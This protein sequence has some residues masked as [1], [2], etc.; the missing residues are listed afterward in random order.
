MTVE[1]YL[2]VTTESERRTQLIDGVIVVNEPK[3]KHDLIQARLIVALGNWVDA[4]EGRGLAFT[5]T[6]VTIDE[7]NLFAPD[8]LWIAEHHLPAD[9]DTYPERIPDICVEVRS[10]STWRHDTG[11]K[12]TG[13][14]RAGLPELWLVNDAARR[15]RVFRRSRPGAP[16]FDVALDL[17]PADELTSPQLPGF[18]LA[19]ERLFR[20]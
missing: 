17:G 19:L 14:E 12:K 8:A 16:A 2:A 9:L 13:Y 4:G 15:V 10:S 6:T 18:A 5:P 20:D 3:L 1:E 11:A 7:H